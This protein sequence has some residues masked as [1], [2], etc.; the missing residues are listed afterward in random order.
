MIKINNNLHP[1]DGFWFR[2]TDGA[3]IRGDS[4]PGVIKRVEEYRARNGYPLGDPEAEV[5]AQ[6]CAR[7]SSRCHNEDERYAEQ[8]KV[9]NMKGKI[10]RWFSWLR[11]GRPTLIAEHHA[12]NRMEVCAA[13]VKNKP[14]TGGCKSC[15][16]AI[17]ELRTEVIG[18]RQRDPRL[19]GCSAA[20]V[21][22]QTAVWLDE[23]IDKTP[24]LVDHCWRKHLP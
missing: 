24:G 12:R 18:A 19:N 2:E 17:E 14:I 22:L 23:G 13:C 4:W 10:L 21:D 20:G 15:S 1:K 11:G 5:T 8:L 16:Q 7:D 9:T 6:V 3:V